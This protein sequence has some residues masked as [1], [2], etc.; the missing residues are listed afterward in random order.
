MGRRRAPLSRELLALGARMR[1]VAARHGGVLTAAQCRLLGADEEALRV[2]L[3]SGAWRRER[4][5][6]YGEP[7]DEERAFHRRCAALLAALGGTAVVSHG[8]AARLLGLPVPPGCAD[9]PVTV[10]RR[11]PASTND[12]L[13]GDVHV[14]GFADADVLLVAGVPVLAGARLVLDCC[15]AMPPDSAL[16]VADAA[17]RRCLT[18]ADGLRRELCRHRG[19]PGTRRA[20]DVLERADPLAESWFESA[21]RWWLLEAGLPR[22]RLQVP[23]RDER[24]RVRARVDLLMPCGRVVGEADGAGKY[25]EPG[26]L[27]AE[28]RREDWLRDAHGVEVVRWVPREMASAGGRAAVVDRFHRAALRV[29][30]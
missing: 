17:L 26:A 21:S 20:G 2:L 28:K 22:P 12:P 8:S 24:G 6:V 4:R 19:R 15:A 13:D 3:R 29:R 25:A 9:D 30:S 23:F 5:G 14:S 10:T 11:P 1:G 16:A 27:F 7:V 18:D